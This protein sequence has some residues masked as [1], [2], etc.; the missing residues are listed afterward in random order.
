ML[1]KYKNFIAEINYIS[2]TSCFYGE[3]IN[4]DCLI[5]FQAE[6]KKDLEEAFKI[7]VEQYIEFMDSIGS[8]AQIVL[9]DQEVAHLEP[10]TLV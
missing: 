5:I 9:L 3:V 8:S 7:A 1:L 6:Y 2:L 4:Q 10:E